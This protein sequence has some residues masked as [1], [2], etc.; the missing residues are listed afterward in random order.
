M[1]AASDD[2]A[3]IGI[4]VLV[5]ARGLTARRHHPEEW[6]EVSRDEASPGS[7]EGG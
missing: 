2:V 5:L 1:S 4:G 6:P 3:I 7:G